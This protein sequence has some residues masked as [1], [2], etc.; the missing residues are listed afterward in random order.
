MPFFNPFHRH[1]HTTFHGVVI[2]LSS[3]PA[4]A[5][6]ESPAVEKKGN[7]NVKTDDSSLN[8]APSQENGSA[9]S[10]PECSHLTIESLRAEI[11]SDIAAS[12]YDS[13]YDRMFLLS[14]TIETWM[15]LFILFPSA[16]IFKPSL[17][18]LGS[19]MFDLMLSCSRQV[20]GH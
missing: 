19:R 17:P 4:H 2:P 11:E 1:D 8:K 5:R 20:E 10:I 6:P 15:L 13:A 7:S 3:A 14:T 12:G 18:F 9:A 16:F